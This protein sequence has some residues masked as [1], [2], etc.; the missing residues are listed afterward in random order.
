VNS[1]KTGTYVQPA[2]GN[3]RSGV[4]YG[5]P[6]APVDGTGGGFGGMISIGHSD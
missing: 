3:V 2:A 6:D 1:E 5:N 4:Q